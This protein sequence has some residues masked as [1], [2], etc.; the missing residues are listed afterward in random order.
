MHRG[1]GASA[2]ASPPAAQRNPDAA[3][4]RRPLAVLDHELQLRRC[5]T[6]GPRQGGPWGLSLSFLRTALEG[7]F[8]QAPTAVG[9]PPT[10]VGYPPTAVGYPPTAVGY[11]PTAVGY[12]P[13]AVG[14]PPTAVG[15][16]PTAVGYHSSFTA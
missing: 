16:P 4:N 14:Y 5:V 7:V 8:P 3:P 9:Y 13:T 6:R 2:A 10:A 1:G 11:P 15:Y 12:P